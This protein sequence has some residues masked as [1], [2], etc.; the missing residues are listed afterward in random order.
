MKQR[1]LADEGGFALKSK[2][3]KRQ[4][5]LTE[6]DA[7]V[8]WARL[9]A[10]IEPFYPKGGNGRPPMPLE[11]ML[12]IHFMQQWFALSDPAME[13]SLYDIPAMRRFAGLDAGEDALPDESTILRFRH[14]LEK[15]GL[16][17][18]L[19]AEVRA[20]LTERGLMVRQG[21][22]VDATLIAAPPST[23]N[24]E[25]KRDPAMSQTKKGNQYYFGAK[26]HIGV[27]AQHALVHTVAV[28][29]AKVADISMTEALLHGSEEIVFGDGGY[30][31]A[32]R[33]LSSARPESGPLILTPYKRRAGQDLTHDQRQQNRALASVRALVEHPFRVLKRQF[34][35]TKVRYK[36]L[37]KNA[38]QITT[39]FA[40]VNLYRVRVPLLIQRER[41]AW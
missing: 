7:V 32:S 12:R 31:K 9:V 15:H 11:T 8:P 25:G 24:V 38:A 41:C 3:T 26:A 6:M 22:I 17:E 19:F 27:D 37:A 35:Y 28:T 18:R 1:S 5:F 30:H 39:L 34:G 4:R 33:T 2:P 10:V 16:A 40:L 14:L 23:K 20:L 29:T 36:G 21:T 13:E